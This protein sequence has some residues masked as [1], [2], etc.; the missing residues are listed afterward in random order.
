MVKN[1][2]NEKIFNKFRAALLDKGK[3]EE[4][5]K[6]IKSSEFELCKRYSHRFSDIVFVKTREER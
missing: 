5:L 6:D 2:D 1:L 3:M 4:I